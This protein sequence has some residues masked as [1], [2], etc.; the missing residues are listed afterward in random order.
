MNRKE[1]TKNYQTE[2]ISLDYLHPRDFEDD[3]NKSISNNTYNTYVRTKR[4]NNNYSFKITTRKDDDKI[5][6]KIKSERAALAIMRIRQAQ[7]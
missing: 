7:K 5:D 6:D 1:K 2:S 4:P 3:K